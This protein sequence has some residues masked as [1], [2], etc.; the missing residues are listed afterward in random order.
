MIALILKRFCQACH[1][2]LK[3][4][5]GG[6]GMF[7][8]VGAVAFVGIAG[9]SVD[10]MRGYLVQSRLSSA[11]DAAGLAGARV[12]YSDTRDADIQMY[13]D[14]NF[15]DGYLG[16]TVTGPI[17]T[18]YPSNE[19]ITLT[20]EATIGT[21]LTQVLGYDNLTVAATSE[22]TRQTEL[23][24]VVLAIDMSGSMNWDIDGNNTSVVADRRITLATNAAK[25]LV[26]I[27]YGTD[28]LAPLLK[29]GVV[30]WSGKVNIMNPNIPFNAGAT[31]TVSVPSFTNPITGLAQSEVYVPN[32]APVPLL[33]TPPAAEPFDDDNGN[34]VRNFGEDYT[35][36]NGNGHYD[37]EW[38]GCVFARYLSGGVGNDADMMVGPAIGVGGKDWPAW[39]VI[40]WQGEPVAGSSPKCPL[41]SG[42]YECTSCLSHGITPLQT[43]K[44]AITGAINDLTSPGGSTEMLGGLAWAWRTLVPAAPF[45]EADPDPE[46]QRTQAII[47]L[48]DGEYTGWSG[49]GYKTQLG[50]NTA[51][52]TLANQRLRDLSTVIK[53]SGVVIY[54]IQF[55]ADSP[56][57][58]PSMKDVA[59]GP[60]SPFYNKAPTAAELQEVFKE[61]AN[62]LSQ[63]R[64]SM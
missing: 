29:I 17:F 9:I 60:D 55:A 48:T 10:A 46:G 16:A 57:L 19:V 45:T 53:E 25:D 52:Q 33:S 61:V 6:M 1:R 23:L 13:F 28:D 34:G 7:M 50:F 8:A 63:L 27:L 40:D 4:E 58:E 2:A 36:V 32:N 44:A 14:A 12:M 42:G 15:P 26:D 62:D 56:T 59:S 18:F 30:P 49:D 31:T 3:D 43:T 5:R 37:V 41:A 20:A 22:I 54:T 39:E 11:L 64:V 21:T 35:D 38:Q 51:A 24:D 47:L